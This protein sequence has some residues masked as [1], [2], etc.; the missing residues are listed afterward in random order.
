MYANID[1]H[2]GEKGI[3]VDI[4]GSKVDIV[5]TF[6]VIFHDLLKRKIINE[7]DIKYIA[8]LSIM[9]EEEVAQRAAE[10]ITKMLLQPKKE[11]EGM[12]KDFNDLIDGFFK[13]IREERKK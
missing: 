5:F 4:T 3:E 1:I 9:S 12:F 6:T 10:I 7:N 11:P 8:E 2:T 13:E